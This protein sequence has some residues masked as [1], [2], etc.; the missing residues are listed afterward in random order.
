MVSP[1]HTALERRLDFWRQVCGCHAGA[2]CALAALAWCIFGYD[3][4]SA[5]TLGA[6]LRGVAVVIGAGVLGKAA[7]VIVA[8]AAFIAETALFIRRAGRPRGG[9]GG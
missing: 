3:H 5:S 1:A 2:L 8:R 4:A 6:V 9:S 7:A